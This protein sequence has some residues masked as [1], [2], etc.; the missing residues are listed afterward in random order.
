MTG[1]FDDGHMSFIGSMSY[2]GS[3]RLV[4]AASC[5]VLVARAP[6]M[7]NTANFLCS[8]LLMCHRPVGRDQWLEQ[9]CVS[10]MLCEKLYLKFHDKKLIVQL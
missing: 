6:L 10:I 8:D 3:I 5:F 2:H 9:H 4:V 1:G 7:T